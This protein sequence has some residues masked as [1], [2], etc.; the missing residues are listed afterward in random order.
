MS[1]MSTAKS[2]ADPDA[3]APGRGPADLSA[4]WRVLAA[5]PD[6]EIPVVSIV[7]LGIVRSVAREEGSVVVRVTPTYSGCPATD[8]I[9][10]AIR[11]EL[12]AIGVPDA[13]VEI[14]LAPAWTTDWVAADAKRRMR[15]FGIAPPGCAI[16]GSPTAVDVRGISPL[17][18]TGFVVP[19]PR[20]G[21]AR[22]RL[23]A[24][25]GSTAC[26]A[27]YRCDECLEPFD[28]FKP[29]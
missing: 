25:F 5:I 2:H 10:A 8:W 26:K 21:S 13:R 20:C 17:R 6:P 28:Y 7:D 9:L 1:T 29:H 24:Q 16:A 12:A 27:L 14:Q 3:A 15:E 23:T 19:C 11:D 22:T 4:V 18:H